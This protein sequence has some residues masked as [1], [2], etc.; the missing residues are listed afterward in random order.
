MDGKKREA[1][2]AE[3][4]ALWDPG[5]GCCGPRGAL[6]SVRYGEARETPRGGSSASCPGRG[7][8]IGDSSAG[9]A[10]GRR[11]YRAFPPLLSPFFSLGCGGNRFSLGASALGDAH[12]G[13][14]PSRGAAPRRRSPL[15]AASEATRSRRGHSPTPAPGAS[16]GT[17][18]AV[19]R[20]SRP[21]GVTG[22]PP[23]GE[24]SNKNLAFAEL[25]EIRPRVL[26]G[27]LT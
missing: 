15:A 25:W 7:A 27:T 11:L 20:A 5:R 10:A 23:R 1:T 4:P 9:T 24:P 16:A 6:S 3:G 26:R 21:P 19:R 22:R 14:L 8:G 17:A 2:S 12:L 18:Q 13:P